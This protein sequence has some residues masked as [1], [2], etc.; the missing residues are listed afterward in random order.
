MNS[1][2]IRILP[3]FLFAEVALCMLAWSGAAAG[4]GMSA[5]ELTRLMDGL[6]SEIKDV[7]FIFEGQVRVLE[8]E[9]GGSSGSPDDGLEYYQGTYAYRSDGATL[10]EVYVHS[11][12]SDVPFQRTTF[13]ALNGKLAE[14]DRIPDNDYNPAPRVTTASQGAFDRPM[15]AER[16]LFLSYFR[17]LSG[18]ANEDFADEGWEEVAGHRC[19]R[20]RINVFPSAGKKSVAAAKTPMPWE[21]LWIDME[22]GGHPLRAELWRGGDLWNRREIEL[23]QLPGPGGKPIWFP[24]RGTTESFVRGDGSVSPQ[25]RVRETYFVVASSPRFNKGLADKLFSV[26]YNGSLP[27]TA[28][29][30]T[31]RRLFQSIPP[32]KREYGPADPENLQRLLD[33]RLA[34]AEKQSSQLDASSTVGTNRDWTLILSV[35]LTSAGILTLG[36]V[37]FLKRRGA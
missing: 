34:Q 6:H 28:E 27:E 31:Q 2:T 15:S 14:L 25:A 36:C 3:G 29:L 24:A 9:K 32:P 4:E 8:R 30:R 17:S 21:R 20:V 33:E 18:L 1:A 19:L 7:W 5:H 37:L 12:R 10:L 26:N 13:A 16:I 22:R 23:V 11:A 35:T